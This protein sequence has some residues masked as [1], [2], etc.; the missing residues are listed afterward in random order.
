MR[1]P[2]L[3]CALEP[4]CAKGPAFKPNRAPNDPFGPATRPLPTCPARPTWSWTSNNMP[5]ERS[6]QGASNDAKLVQQLSAVQ[7][8]SRAKVIVPFLPVS[9]VWL[10]RQNA[11]S[12]TPGEGL[13]E[14]ELAK[15]NF[16]SSS[17]HDKQT[18]EF[19]QIT[20]DS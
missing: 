17:R 15:G 12:I 10:M 14:Q 4:D 16:D 3:Q 8:Q 19:A 1:G 9:A 2:E 11:H 13:A 7:T 5:F 18:T 6:H 20:A